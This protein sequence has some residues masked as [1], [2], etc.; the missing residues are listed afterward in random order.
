MI[1]Q[2]DEDTNVTRAYGGSHPKDNA[3]SI[4]GQRKVNQDVAD[5]LTKVGKMKK[6]ITCSGA[7]FKPFPLKRILTAHLSAKTWENLFDKFFGE[8]LTA[9]KIFTT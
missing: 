5:L 2:N 3:E 6:Q 7:F 8:K 1:T 4:P 9:A